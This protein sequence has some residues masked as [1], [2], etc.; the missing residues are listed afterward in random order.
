[1]SALS[2]LLSHLLAA[3]AVLAEPVL[4]VRMYGNLQ[5]EAGH[6]D[7][8]RRRFYRLGLAVE[9]AWVLVVGLIVA[10][11]G[12]SWGELGLRWEDPPAEVLGF[13]VAVILGGLVPVAAIWLRSLRPGAPG[14]RESFERM[15][16]PVGAMLPRTGRERRLFAALSVT[17]GVCEEIL[18][19]GFLLFYL[20]EVF[21]GV[22]VVGA[23][24]LS[25]AVFGL[26]H[27][28]QG[29]AGVLGTG[30]FGA[31]MAVL[32]FFS[33]SLVL[34]ILL[35]AL[36]DLRILLIHRSGVRRTEA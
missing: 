34:P 3:Y 14:A 21:P 16:E 19:R 22:G 29:V 32:Y 33:G 5:R 20:Q 15:L 13:V 31:G 30:L 26:A 9:W 10:F 8:A 7:G 27:L 23:V 36:L 25:S 12:P 24:V 17:A 35:H 18:F 1:M 4:G 2:L 6:D 11:G 28:Y